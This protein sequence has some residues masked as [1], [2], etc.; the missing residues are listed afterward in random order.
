MMGLARVSGS[1]WYGSFRSAVEF[2]VCFEYDG[3][4]SGALCGCM[5]LKRQEGTNG[6]MARRKERRV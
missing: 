5:H 4:K 2:S 3:S 1:L 6:M